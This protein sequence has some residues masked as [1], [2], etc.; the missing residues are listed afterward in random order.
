MGGNGRRSTLNVSTRSE[1]TRTA[2]D[3]RIQSIHFFNKMFWYSRVLPEASAADLDAAP[4]DPANS[5]APRLCKQGTWVRNFKWE[6][7]YS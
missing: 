3:R 1:F 5:Y 4:F 7:S 2:D 6:T